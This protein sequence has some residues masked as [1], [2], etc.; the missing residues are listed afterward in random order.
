[1][2]Q[3]QD[4]PSTATAGYDYI[5]VGGGS[6]GCLLANRLSANSSIRVL[7]KFKTSELKF[8]VYEKMVMSF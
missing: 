3:H 4:K 2:T 6:A 5:I 7:Q 1:M 8:Q